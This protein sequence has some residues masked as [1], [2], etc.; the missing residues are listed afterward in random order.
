MCHPVCECVCV[1]GGSEDRLKDLVLP[2]YHM[3]SRD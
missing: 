1:V 3:G 2:F